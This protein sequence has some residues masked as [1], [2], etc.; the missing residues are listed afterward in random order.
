MVS[1][2]NE[3]CKHEWDFFSPGPSRP[4]LFSAGGGRLQEAA[5]LVCTDKYSWLSC[6]PHRAKEFLS[7]M[8][9]KVRLL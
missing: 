6:C 7:Q 5:F 9:L 8:L 4:L 2:E 1:L 3:F